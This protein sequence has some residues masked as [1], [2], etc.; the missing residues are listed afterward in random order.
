MHKADT[1]NF[2]NP[3]NVQEET[4]RE[5][6]DQILDA[7][8]VIFMDGAALSHQ[9]STGAGEMVYMLPVLPNSS[10]NFT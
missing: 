7:E 10:S 4:V 5:M 8:I 3:K 6:L 2:K 1:E 9:W